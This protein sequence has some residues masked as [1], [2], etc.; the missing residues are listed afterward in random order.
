MKSSIHQLQQRSQQNKVDFLF[1]INT[2]FQHCYQVIESESRTTIVNTS[3]ATVVT[4]VDTTTTTTTAATTTE[5]T[6]TTPVEQPNDQRRGDI[7]PIVYDVQTIQTI[8]S[9]GT[10]QTNRGGAGRQR[11]FISSKLNK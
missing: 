2:L 7:L 3:L 9:G 6:N 10:G 1:F 8:G 11:P 5:S 4:N